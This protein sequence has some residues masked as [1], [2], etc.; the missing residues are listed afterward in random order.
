MAALTVA[1]LASRGL[2]LVML[3]AGAH[4]GDTKPQRQ[5][6]EAPKPPAHTVKLVLRITGLNREGCT[7]EIKPAHPGCAF[8]ARTEHVEADGKAEIAFADVR[9]QSADRDCTFAI[10]IRESGQA[11]R[12]VY[13]GLRL[14]PAAGSEQ[15]LE[16]F[17]SS[18]SRIAKANEKAAPKR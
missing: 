17:L 15:S 13:R 9:T 8:R 2:V 16:C 3:P 14:K 11:E 4:A 12:T 18:P 10:T 6:Q 1:A 7:V 5:A